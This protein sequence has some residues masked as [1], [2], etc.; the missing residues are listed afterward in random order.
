MADGEEIT[1]LI[2]RAKCAEQAERYDDM[3]DYM[4]QVTEL[5]SKEGGQ[6]V[7]DNTERNLLSVAYKNVVGS[8]RSSWRV[9]S[10]LEQK[11]DNDEGKKRLI[12]TYREKI[13][14]ELTEICNTVLVSFSY[15]FN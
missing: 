6:N 8:R 3:S 1:K 4:K 11:T 10:S 9:I 14:K 15:I 13:E 5:R 7:L 12:E 2:E